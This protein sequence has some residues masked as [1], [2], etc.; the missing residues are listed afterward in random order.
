MV[1]ADNAEANTPCFL[2]S[3][4]KCLFNELDKLHLH[5]KYGDSCI[6]TNSGSLS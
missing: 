4:N 2:L 6:T 3:L 1:G 5:S